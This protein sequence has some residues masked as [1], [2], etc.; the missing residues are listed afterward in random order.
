MEGGGGMFGGGGG[1]W[2]VVGG[3]GRLWVKEAK[4]ASI[5]TRLRG[6]RRGRRRAEENREKIGKGTR[7]KA[8]TRRHFQCLSLLTEKQRGIEEYR[9]PENGRDIRA[10]RKKGGKRNSRRKLNSMTLLEINMGGWGGGKEN[11]TKG[12]KSQKRRGTSAWGWVGGDRTK[13]KDSRPIKASANI[14][15]LSLCRCREGKGSHSK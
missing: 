13:K 10:R 9:G 12:E 6:A 1:V 3:G 8:V 7:D 2:C 4:K 5:P 15:G 11:R 14:S